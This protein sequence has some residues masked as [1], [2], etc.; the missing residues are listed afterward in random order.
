MTHFCD[1]GQ[2]LLRL[3]FVSREQL[4]SSKQKLFPFGSSPHK[5]SPNGPEHAQ[6]LYVPHLP[7]TH[8]PVELVEVVD[9]RIVLDELR[10]EEKEV[11]GVVVE[12]DLVV[13]MVDV[14]L[15]VDR[16]DLVVEV[17]DDDKTLEDLMEDNDEESTAL[18]LV[19]GSEEVDAVELLTRDDDIADV[20]EETAPAVVVIDV[21]TASAANFS[22]V[23]PQH[24]Q[25]EEY[26]A[27]EAQT[28]AYTGKAA[29]VTAGSA[30]AGIVAVS[31]TTDDLELV[32]QGYS[33]N[34]AARHLRRRRD[35]GSCG[36]KPRTVLSA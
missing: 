23:I 18:D 7:P 30:V 16:D 36:H 11:M 28:E 21:G 8:P 35:I 15:L 24:E 9:V 29:D 1:E 3:Q 25:A 14:E 12:E 33:S 34:C 5:Q 26:A 13:G 4:L 19:V 27:A 20:N 2:S 22:V 10:V 32:S 31:F 6:D 17:E